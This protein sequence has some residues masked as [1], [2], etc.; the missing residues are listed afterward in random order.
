MLAVL[1][2]VLCLFY[3]LSIRV[4]ANQPYYR[5]LVT[6][7]MVHGIVVGLSIMLIGMTARVMRQTTV[8][9][10]TFVQVS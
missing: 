5:I 8:L 10:H 2:N 9:H 1:M 4:P 7:P 3:Q 6:P